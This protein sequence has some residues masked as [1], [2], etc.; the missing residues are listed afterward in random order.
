MQEI[1]YLFLNKQINTIYIKLNKQQNF[2]PFV[3]PNQL[4]N[5]KILI[6]TKMYAIKNC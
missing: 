5:N 4:A 6:R 2:T 3:K 1:W